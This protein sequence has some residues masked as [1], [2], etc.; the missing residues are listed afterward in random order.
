MV[1]F[2]TAQI[3]A[4]LAAFVW[5]FLRILALVGTA[6]IFKDQSIPTRLKIGLALVLTAL[7]APLLPAAPVALTSAGAPFAIAQQLVVGSALGFAMRIVFAAVELA[8]DQIGL[9]MGLSF[10]SAV[11]PQS[12]TPSPLIA[13]FL[14]LLAALVYLALNGHLHLLAV[15]IESFSVWPIAPTTIAT[16]DLLR[17]VAW[18]GELFRFG[19]HLAL[20]VLATMLVVNLAL[21][22]LARS[23][24]QLSIFAV[25]FPAT[26]LAGFALLAALLPSFAPVFQRAV[27]SG[28]QVLL[29]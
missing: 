20:P 2:T 6:P 22:V 23:A 1:S 17:L 12:G 26:L 19:L 10:A 13:S 27:E 25:G 15:L 4:W 14:G 11:D 18:S 28:L 16:V 8:G 7:V 24:P 9:Q 3:G 5:P 21:G 29:R